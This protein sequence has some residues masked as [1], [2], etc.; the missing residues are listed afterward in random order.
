[1][2]AGWRVCSSKSKFNILLKKK[3]KKKVCNNLSKLLLSESCLY[4]KKWVE[5]FNMYL[6]VEG[7]LQCTGTKEILPQLWVTIIVIHKIF[8]LDLLLVTMCI[9]PMRHSYFGPS[10][11]RINQRMKLECNPHKHTYPLYI[12]NTVLINLGLKCSK[13]FDRDEAFSVSL[14]TLAE[15][16]LRLRFKSQSALILFS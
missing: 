11:E 16:G 5:F 1:M 9:Y 12:W 3:K 15:R 10:L 4:L 6:L 8:S 7:F 13:L 14:P 2:L